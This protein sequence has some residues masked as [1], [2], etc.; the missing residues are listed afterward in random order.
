[1]VITSEM[2][3]KGS[4]QETETT[5]QKVNSVVMGHESQQMR[6]SKKPSYQPEDPTQS[7][8]ELVYQQQVVKKDKLIENSLTQTDRTNRLSKEIGII[9]EDKKQTV[10]LESTPHM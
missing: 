5:N 7:A 6:V 4:I 2:G 8:C 3:K 9:K 10:N 1:M